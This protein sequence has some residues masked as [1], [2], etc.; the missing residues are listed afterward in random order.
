MSCKQ[1]VGALAAAS[2][3]SLFVVI[4]LPTV[5]FVSLNHRENEVFPNNLQHY[6]LMSSASV[7]PREAP[8]LSRALLVQFAGV[9]GVGA[10]NRQAATTSPANAPGSDMK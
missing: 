9:S 5:D 6:S 1:G 7:L 3:L 10:T 2:I 4:S 8:P